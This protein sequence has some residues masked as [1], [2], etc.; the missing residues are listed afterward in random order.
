MTGHSSTLRH[1][2]ES[3]DPVAVRFRAETAEDEE[4][5]R[6]ISASSAVSARSNPYWAPAFAGVA[7]R[8]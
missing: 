4:V 3:G 2:R 6:Y 1:P 5:E 8:G 7:N